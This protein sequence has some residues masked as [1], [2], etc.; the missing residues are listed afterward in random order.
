MAL[1]FPPNPS[2]GAQWTIGNKSYVWSGKAWLAVNSPLSATSA[3]FSD[4]TNAVS[5][6]TGAVTV[7]GGVGI[8]GDLYVGGRIVSSSMNTGTEV[9]SNTGTF[10]KVLITGGIQATSTNSGDLTVAGGVG[11]GGNLYIGGILYSGGAPVLTTASFNNTAQDG[12]DID[13]VDLGGGVLQ[14]NNISTLQSVTSRGSATS[15]VITITNTT[16]AT[17]TTTGA[18][19][20]AGG[21]GIGGRVYAD[22]LRIADV[23]LDSSVHTIN[24]TTDVVIDSFNFNEYRSA[25]YLV[26]ID[27][28][29][30]V[31]SRCQ[32]TELAILPTRSGTV[33]IAE[34]GSVMSDTDLAEFDAE[35]LNIGGNPIVILYISATDD[36]TKTV[37]VLRTALAA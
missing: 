15:N 5:S 24:T 10:K 34:F 19:T 36:K 33:N 13:V 12:Q 3:T 28:G 31:G 16:S 14:F 35:L 26:Q 21:V 6:T 1:N 27:E 2:L 18:L 11:I 25:K 17:S 37:T 23:I 8:Q 9:V 30:G 32:M 29:S 7:A 20:V 22:S 4:T